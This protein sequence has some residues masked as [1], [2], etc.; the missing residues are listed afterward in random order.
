MVSII[1][2]FFQ[3]YFPEPEIE[4]PNISITI[5]KAELN[6]KIYPLFVKFGCGF[7]DIKITQNSYNSTWN[8]EF[9]L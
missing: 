7:D 9:Y 6:K 4:E 3:Q 2:N 8:E 1:R 5:V